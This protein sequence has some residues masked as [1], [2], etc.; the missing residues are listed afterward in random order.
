MRTVG[1]P[2]VD[3]LCGLRILTKLA[4][5]LVPRR[6]IFAAFARVKILPDM[7]VK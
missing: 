7:V 2:S 5:L 6:R 1:A 4:E 3:H